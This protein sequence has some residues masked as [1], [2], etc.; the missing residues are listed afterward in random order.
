L[1]LVELIQDQHVHRPATVFKEKRIQEPDLASGHVIVEGSNVGLD[2]GFRGSCGE[3]ER[4]CVRGI[5]TQ[6]LLHLP[7]YVPALEAR[8]TLR[9]DGSVLEG[10]KF[11]ARLIG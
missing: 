8:G 9:G 3:L 5:S 10:V 6:F 7:G 11:V 2:P 1:V 4:L